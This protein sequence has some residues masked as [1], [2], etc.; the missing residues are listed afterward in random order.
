MS[1]AARQI[2]LVAGREVT[3]RLRSKAFV[4]TTVGLVVAIVAGGLLLHLATG[5]SS[6]SK[7]ALVPATQGLEQP[8]QTVAAASGTEIETVREPDDDAARAAVRAGDVDVALTGR[9]DAFSVV[10]KDAVPDR[11]GGPLAALRQQRALDAAVTELGG[12]PATVNQQLAAATLDVQVLEPQP[13]RDGAQIVAGYLV[14]IL[15]FIAL[16]TCAQLVA[17]GV[18]EEKTSRVVELLLSTMKPWQLMTGKVLGIGLV[19]LLQVVVVVAASAVTALATG[20]LDTSSL[21]VSTTAVWAL[22]WFVVGFVTYAF[23]IGALAALVSRQEDVGSVT[24]PVVMLMIVPYVIAVSV[25]PWSPDS[26]LVTWLSYLPFTAPMVMPVRAALGSV[27]T[28]QV[29]LSVLIS[30]A[31]VPALI[32]L[33]GRVYNNAVLRSGAKVR[34]RDALRGT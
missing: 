33:S 20:L 7:V 25:A 19:G 18:V 24:G 27:E 16:Q 32:W 8:L 6:A 29:A 4:W 15:L 30:V 31:C 23:V 22:V 2:G 1:P 17:T 9:A 13:E 11:L 34:L 28:W 3:T 26:P 10:V 21:D 12:D 14:G 5:S